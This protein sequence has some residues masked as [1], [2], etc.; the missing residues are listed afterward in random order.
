MIGDDVAGMGKFVLRTGTVQK[1]RLETVAQ[2]LLAM[3]RRG[4]TMTIVGGTRILPSSD[5]SGEPLAPT[6]V[7]DGNAFVRIPKGPSPDGKETYEKDVEQ[8]HCSPQPWRRYSSL[9][10]LYVPRRSPPLDPPP[11]PPLR[12]PDA[13]ATSPRPLPT[14]FAGLASQPPGAFDPQ[15]KHY[16]SR[17]A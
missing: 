3:E 17:C 14:D 4:L 6:V 10:L 5:A 8:Q 15:G 2:V 7:R 12:P 9:P 16:S 1:A 13:P 11:S